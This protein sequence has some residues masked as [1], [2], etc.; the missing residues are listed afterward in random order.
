MI[1]GIMAATLEGHVAG[2]DGGVQFLGDFADVDRGFETFLAR[3]G[4]VVI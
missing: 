2:A 4:T 3:I 1:R